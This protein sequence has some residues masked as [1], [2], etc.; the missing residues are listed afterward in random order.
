MTELPKNPRPTHRADAIAVECA[1]RRRADHADSHR[2]LH[3]NGMYSSLDLRP[4]LLDARRRTLELVSDL[5]DRQLALPETDILNPPSWGTR[6][7]AP[8]PHRWALP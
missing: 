8:V 3:N 5:S 2:T 6:H 1:A 7:P 4:S